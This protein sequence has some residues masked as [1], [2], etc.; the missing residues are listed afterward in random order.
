M[1]QTKADFVSTTQVAGP[2]SWVPTNVKP[3]ETGWPTLLLEATG[4]MRMS[5]IVI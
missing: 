4:T 5:I 3:P 2:A 1:C